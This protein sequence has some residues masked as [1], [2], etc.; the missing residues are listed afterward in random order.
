[1]DTTDKNLKSNKRGKE[2]KILF[3]KPDKRDGELRVFLRRGGF[4]YH[5]KG[6]LP[7]EEVK[8][9]IERYSG[10]EVFCNLMSTEQPKNPYN[11]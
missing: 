5:I 8:A 2:E 7:G 1:M 9:E 4:R 11:Y 10:M 3:L 6:A